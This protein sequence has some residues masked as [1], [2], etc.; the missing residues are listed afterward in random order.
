MKSYYT[1]VSTISYYYLG[2]KRLFADIIHSIQ[3]GY[4]LLQQML[5]NY[6]MNG[7]ESRRW[8]FQH[9]EG[10]DMGKDS[11]RELKRY[12]YLL[13]EIDAQYHEMSL[14]LGLSNSAMMILYAI[15]D[16]GECCLLREICRRTG[17]SKKTINSA[18][19]KLEREG[20]VYL[21]S[22]G[23]K[24]KNVCLTK[25]GKRLAEDTVMRIMEA[26]NEILAAWPEEDVE[27]YLD[28]TERFLEA[29]REKAVG[30]KGGLRNE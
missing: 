21:E 11:Y 28:L 2:V 30:M 10:E 3:Y 16:S 1:V 7:C 26:E 4:V 12:N 22:A 19:R 8:N 20:M 17:I 14:K 27:R 6:G 23:V 15:C 29:I 5:F 18:I 25:Q 13:G 24:N 9:R